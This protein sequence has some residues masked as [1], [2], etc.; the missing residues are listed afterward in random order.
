MEPI[1]PIP[2]STGPRV[3]PPIDTEDPAP[4]NTDEANVETPETFRPPATVTPYPV[5]SNFFAVSV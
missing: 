2:E 1:C 5:V 4:T 3:V